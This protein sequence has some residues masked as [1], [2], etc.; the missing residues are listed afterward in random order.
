MTFAMLLGPTLRRFGDVGAQLLRER[1]IVIGTDAELFA[2]HFDSVARRRNVV[3]KISQ[4]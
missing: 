3:M 4:Y 1:A 2:V